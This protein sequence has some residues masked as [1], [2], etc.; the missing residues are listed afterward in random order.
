[1][2][3]RLQ[4]FEAAGL[5]ASRCRKHAAFRLFSGCRIHAAAVLGIVAGLT[6]SA[7]T[8]KRG[9]LSTLGPAPLSFRLP[10]A[11]KPFLL[12]PLKQP[13]TEDLS[14]PTEG[15]TAP[16]PQA[17]G[18][19]TPL[20]PAPLSAPPLDE[21]LQPGG[22]PPAL[23]PVQTQDEA[24]ARAAIN[25]QLVLR[26]LTPGPTNALTERFLPPV[27]IPPGPPLPPPCS[28]ATYEQQ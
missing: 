21:W 22:T 25:P 8:P 4:W 6:A 11:G 19:P 2:R 1:M 18:G 12:P 9:Y 24:A 23:P 10:S 20:I 15:T 3:K 5:W 16:A 17:A 28:R 14:A 26:Y 13:K 7:V 27:F